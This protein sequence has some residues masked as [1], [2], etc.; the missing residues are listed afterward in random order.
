MNVP[1][2]PLAAFFAVIAEALALD[3]ESG[4]CEDDDLDPGVM[5]PWGE[6]I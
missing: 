4:W 2:D 1:Q 6:L 3:D 5:T